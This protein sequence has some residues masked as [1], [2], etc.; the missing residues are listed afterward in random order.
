MPWQPEELVHHSYHIY[1]NMEMSSCG[2][3]ATSYLVNGLIVTVLLKK[4]HD[5]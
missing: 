4:G 5:V 3:M 1:N 2:C